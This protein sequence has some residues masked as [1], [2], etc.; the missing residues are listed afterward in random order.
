M[1]RNRTIE[2]KKSIFED[3]YSSFPEL[4]KN[5]AILNEPETINKLVVD[6]HSL[7]EKINEKNEYLG[8][9]TTTISKV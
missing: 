3:P 9:L 7:L 4:K 6:W 8:H 1:T 5:V 2:H